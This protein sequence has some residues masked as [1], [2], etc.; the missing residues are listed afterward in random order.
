MA[1]NEKKEEKIEDVKE[2]KKEEV[3]KTENKTA[4]FKK[5]A[6]SKENVKTTNQQKQTSKATKAKVATKEKGAKR[7]M[8]L[9]ILAVVIVL[10]AIISLIYVALP[11]PAKVLQQALRDM[12]IGNFERVKEYLDFDE[13]VN[14]PVLSFDNRDDKQDI[15]K[16]FFNELE[17][18]IKSVKNEGDTAKIEVEI[19][20]KN[21][22]TIMQNYT[23]NVMQKLFSNDD[24]NTEDILIEQLKNKEIDKVTSKQT[25]TVQKQDG[26]WKVVVDENL[27]NAIFPGLTEVLDSVTSSAS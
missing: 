5:V 18:N 7:A 26:E 9:R 10:L 12:Q 27:R 15:Q 17:F 2:V 11:S 8:L 22:K 23:K 3:N 1:E 25:V 19:T 20:N 13:L 21:F 14:I 6:P 16:L 24:T 4:E